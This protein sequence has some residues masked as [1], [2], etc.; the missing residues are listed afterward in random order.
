VP[1]AEVT[2]DD[3]ADGAG[4]VAGGEGGEQAINDASGD[5][6]EHGRG[7]VTRED[8]EDD[9]VVE[10]TCAE[11]RQQDDA[12]RS[13]IADGEMP[14]DWRLS[15]RRTNARGAFCFELGPSRY[16]YRGGSMKRLFLTVALL[17]AWRSRLVPSCRR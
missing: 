10:P 11:A 15:A 8:A 4:E 9:E 5:A 17:L 1:V 6:A 14:I 16:R 13:S 3:A 2:E 7:D 12:P